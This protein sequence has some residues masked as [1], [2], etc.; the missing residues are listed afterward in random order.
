MS[1]EPSTYGQYH[2]FLLLNGL[3]LLPFSFLV[4]A[5]AAVLVRSLEPS[6]PSAQ[7]QAGK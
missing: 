7:A 1:L 5:H 6:F 3:G 2:L 4:Y